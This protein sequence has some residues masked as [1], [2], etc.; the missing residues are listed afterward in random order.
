MP[1]AF[2]ILPYIALLTA[3]LYGWWF[4]DPTSVFWVLGGI[5]VGY[6]LGAWWLDQTRRDWWRFAVTPT[7]LA[8]AALAFSLLIPGKGGALSVLVVAGILQ[9]LYWRY[10]YLY[11]ARPGNYVPFSL[12][13]LGA[14]LDFLTVYFLTAAGYGLKTFLDVP[15]WMLAL[16]FALLISLLWSQWLWVGKINRAVGWRHAAVAAVV[17]TEL[18]LLQYFSP[19]DFRLLA[20]PVA[21]GYYVLV[22]LMSLKMA[23]S[24]DRRKIYTLGAVLL[25]SWL[26]V[27]LTARWF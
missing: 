9:L 23:G 16:A 11:A 25:V 6:L 18:F 24:L 27:F 26:A 7:L 19:L 5:V 14:S 8:L 3:G 12:E 21:S 4:L 15:T 17:L 20:F 2:L 10:A 13:R 22:N 1:Y